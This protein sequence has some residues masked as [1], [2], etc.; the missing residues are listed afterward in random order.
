MSLCVVDIRHNKWTNFWF[1]WLVQEICWV[2]LSTILLS[3]RNVSRIHFEDYYVCY[4]NFSS[5]DILNACLKIIHLVNW[6]PMRIHIIWKKVPLR[7]IFANSES[8]GRNLWEAFMSITTRTNF[9]RL[10]IHL[11]YHFSQE[12]HRNSEFKKYQNSIEVEL[13]FQRCKTFIFFQDFSLLF[14]ICVFF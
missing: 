9:L 3:F 2:L 11:Q 5:W 8:W 6:E 7:T 14:N 12:P 4:T 1:G 10:Y 13:I